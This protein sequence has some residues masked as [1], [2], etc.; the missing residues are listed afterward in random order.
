MF[1]AIVV[2]CIA[3]GLFKDED[4]TIEGAVVSKKTCYFDVDWISEPEFCEL[5]IAC[6]AIS[7]LLAVIFILIDFIA[8]VQGTEPQMSKRLYAASA[9]VSIAMVIL[10]IA[11]FTYMYVFCL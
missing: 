2:G 7:V 10:W 3:G 9:T 11:C 1:G 5:G 8:D 6:G 4:Y